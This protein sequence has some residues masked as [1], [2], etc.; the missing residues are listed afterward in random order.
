MMATDEAAGKKLKNVH[1]IR[2]MIF[3]Y[4]NEF[5]SH[6]FYTATGSRLG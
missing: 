5:F 3:L 1:Y 6:S 4:K 2:D